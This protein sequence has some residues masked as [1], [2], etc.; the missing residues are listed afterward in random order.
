MAEVY[1]NAMLTI[2]ATSSVSGSVSFLNLD[3]DS[4]FRPRDIMF[5][6]RN[7]PAINLKARRVPPSTT[8]GEIGIGPLATRGWAVQERALSRRILC[9]DVDELRYSCCCENRCECRVEAELSRRPAAIAADSEVA[10]KI[11]PQYGAWSRIWWDLIWDY[12]R[13]DLTFPTDRLPALS[14]IAWMIER[15]AKM[16][17]LAGLWKQRLPHDLCWFSIPSPATVERRKDWRV[18]SDVY[19]APSF[20]WASVGYNI[21]GPQPISPETSYQSFAAVIHVECKPAS[22][23]SP[24]GKV[25]DGILILR[26]PCVKGTLS[27]SDSSDQD[28]YQIELASTSHSFRPDCQLRLS[29]MRYQDTRREATVIRATQGPAMCIENAHVCCL[30]VEKREQVLRLLVLGQSRKDMDMFERLGLL[31]I[32]STASEGSTRLGEAHSWQQNLIEGGEVSVFH[33]L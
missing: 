32:V 11:Q 4:S 33:I 2:V 5:S 18:A 3:R 12:T 10:C 21:A 19:L 24:F 16:Q 22:E 25:F 14:G 23:A 1:H 15:E 31:Q 29:D 27:C 9:Y 30:I 6:D 8:H 28:T 17:Y 13:A 7:N 20:S 26:A